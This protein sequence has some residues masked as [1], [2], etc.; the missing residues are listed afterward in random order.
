MSAI[1]DFSNIRYKPRSPRSKGASSA[2][3]AP[4]ADLTHF[5]VEDADADVAAQTSAL[6]SNRRALILRSLRRTL[7]LSQNVHRFVNYGGLEQICK[8]I[9][10]EPHDLVLFDAL[11]LVQQVCVH[12]PLAVACAFLCEAYIGPFLKLARCRSKHVRREFSVIL[13]MLSRNSAARDLL[14]GKRDEILSILR[15]HEGLKSPLREVRSS[16]LSVTH[17][18]M[19]N[20]SWRSAIQEDRLIKRHVAVIHESEDP[21][22]PGVDAVRAEVVLDQVYDDKDALQRE[23]DS[24]GNDMQVLSAYKRSL[25]EQMMEEEE[26]EEEAGEAAGTGVGHK[27]GRS[28][29]TSQHAAAVRRKKTAISPVAFSLPHDAVSNE[30]EDNAST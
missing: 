3:G 19:R 14:A 11:Q 6:R 24:V 5:N 23:L 10:S 18:L 13:Y 17:N 30:E 28:V 8:L 4:T 20:E 7:S 12:E 16:M 27:D 21:E 29:V 2:G 9:E 25:D 1:P 15:G 26:E 22:E